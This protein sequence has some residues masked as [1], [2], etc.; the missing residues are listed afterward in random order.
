MII[1]QKF[2]TAIFNLPENESDAF[3]NIVVI[4]LPIVIGFRFAPELVTGIATGVL[5]ISVTDGPGNLKGKLKTAWASLLFYTSLAFVFNGFLHDPL[6]SGCLFGVFSFLLAFW[7]GTGP[8]GVSLGIP[9]IGLMIFSLGLRPHD[10][11]MFSVYIAVGFAWFQSIVLLQTYLWPFR[12]LQQELKNLLRLN[13]KFLYARADCYNPEVP[14][15]QAY[16][17][18]LN[19]H[20]LITDKQESV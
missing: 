7:S 15:D 10:P 16:T 2:H 8:L 17:K 19:L 1:N 5:I 13:S 11:V 3:R 14:L 20:L 12:S 18:A 4:F 9:A 6:T